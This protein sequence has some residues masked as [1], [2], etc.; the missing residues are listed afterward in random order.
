[1]QAPGVSFS[2]ALIYLWAGYHGARRTRLIKT[3]MLAAAGTSFV[4]FTILFTALAIR[5]PG[6]LFAPFAKPFI[7]VILATLLLIALGYGALAGT[8]GAIFGR[9]TAPDSPK[10][11]QVA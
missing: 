1:V 6:L 8:V 9:W 10:D 3:G 5:M 2:D 11:T 4:G 7:F